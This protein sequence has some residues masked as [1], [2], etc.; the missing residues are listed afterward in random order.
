VLIIP[1]HE[2]GSVNP[3]PVR[4]AVASAVACVAVVG[5]ALVGAVACTSPEQAAPAAPP[6]AP[7]ASSQAGAPDQQG[8]A[9]QAATIDP[10]EQGAAALSALGG[11]GQDQGAGQQVRDLGGQLATDGQAL[12]E[13]LQGVG[14]E[15]DGTLTPELQAT[16][17]DL[18][19]RTGEQFDQ[20]W[21]RAAMQAQEQARNAANAVLDSPDAS[22][23]AKAAARA[24]LTRLDALS[25]ALQQAAG[26]AGATTPGAVEAGSGGQAAGGV[27]PAAAVLVWA[28]VVLL[29]GA[30][31]WRRRAA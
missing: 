31:W 1:P 27:A 29:G 4:Q 12:L 20:A 18:Q 6:P 7:A 14:G 24:A 21:L 9:D 5:L 15:F 28:G 10:A 22:E 26:S 23:E 2:G 30:V 17:A 3:R 19:A 13:Q 11:L 25:A 16:L 8:E